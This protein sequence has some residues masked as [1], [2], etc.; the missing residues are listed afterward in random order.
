MRLQHL[1]LLHPQQQYQGLPE[2]NVPFAGEGQTSS[3]TYTTRIDYTWCTARTCYIWCLQTSTDA[4]RLLLEV[5]GKAIYAY[6]HCFPNK[7]LE[8]KKFA[9]ALH[10]LDAVGVKST[11]SLTTPSSLGAKKKNLLVLQ[12]K[13]VMVKSSPCRS[14][15]VRTGTAIHGYARVQRSHPSIGFTGVTY[16]MP[17]VLCR[18]GVMPM[19]IERHPYAKGGRSPN[20]IWQRC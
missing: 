18:S 13:P 15:L 10:S 4:Y 8:C 2:T 9:T 19:S 16:S 12:E 20:P 3:Q 14:A 5:T 7:I 17:G 11:A 1:L 6:R